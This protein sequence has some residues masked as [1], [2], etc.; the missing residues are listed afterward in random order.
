MNSIRVIKSVLPGLF[1]ALGVGHRANADT[2]P[3]FEEQVSAL[4]REVAPATVIVRAY[5][6]IPGAALGLGPA[7]ASSLMDVTTGVIIDSNGSIVCP[8]GTLVGADSVTVMYRGQSLRA[9]IV[10][11]DYRSGLGL[12]GVFGR[13]LAAAHIAERPVQTGELAALVELDPTGAARPTIG[14]VTSS[15]QDGRIEFTGGLGAQPMCGGVFDLHGGLIGV[16][17]APSGPGAPRNRVMA[18]SATRVAAIASRLSCCGDRPAGYL[19]VQ[20][21]SAQIEITSPEP[22]FGS[23]AHG[24]ATVAS[25]AQVPDPLIGAKQAALVTAVTA[26]SPAALA[27]L[28]PGDVIFAADGFRIESAEALRDHI[29]CGRPDSAMNVSFLRGPER[30]T[31]RVRLASARLPEWQ[32]GGASSGLGLRGEVGDRMSDSLLR[33]IHELEQRLRSLEATVR[34]G[35]R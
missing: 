35:D 23:A 22:A 25:E 21:V 30:M 16:V 8:A 15:G 18:I 28:A 31:C 20:V 34:S 14:F 9:R 26:G 13:D 10:G 29:T 4:V 33:V 32:T 24:L 27:G 12:V 1:L 7:A 5:T 6:T 2:N 11:V 17:M 3:R 19:G